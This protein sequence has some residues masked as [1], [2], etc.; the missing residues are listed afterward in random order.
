MTDVFSDTHRLSD[1]LRIMLEFFI[2]LLSSLELTLLKFYFIFITVTILSFA[3]PR[4]VE[5]Y[6]RCLSIHLDI[7]SP[8]IRLECH[9]INR[10]H[11]LVFF[12]PIMIGDF[13]WK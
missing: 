1:L 10:Y 2:Q 8:M 4:L 13:R 7:L 3:V 6:V 12:F 11:A 5:L 9:M